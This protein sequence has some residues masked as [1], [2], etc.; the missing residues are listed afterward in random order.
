[1]S[2]LAASVTDNAD[3]YGEGFAAV[4][5]SSRY[6]V[7]SRRLAKLA[8][9]LLRQYEAPG[10]DLLDLA[11]G[12][13]AG[14]VEFA[15]AG[16]TV[17]GVDRSP[18]MLERAAA[19]ARSAGVELRVAQQDMQTLS[20]PHQVDVVTCMFDALNYLIEE[21][22]LAQAFVRVAAV[23]RL[24]GLFI[25]D[26]NTKRGLAMRWGTG[27]QVAT[28]RPDV[29]ELNQ[30]RFDAERALSTVTTTIFVHE[31]GDGLYR[32]Y[33]EVHRER[34]YPVETLVRLLDAAGMQ[35]LALRGL[36][37]QFQGLAVG[38]EPYNEDHGRVV[39]VARRAHEDYAR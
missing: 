17:S 4:Y 28:M 16:Y 9:S 21:D 39:V 23:L 11:C 30:Y 5:A 38:L 24:G 6:A 1:M 34:A 7:F 13:G 12:A 22:D 37:E 25:F 10:A 14:S 15:A 32:R 36:S 26:M 3:I 33:A 19:N 35:V 2:Y 31:D 18:V 29:V 20:L 27:S 8:L